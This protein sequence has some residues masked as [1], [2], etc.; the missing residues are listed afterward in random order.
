MAP[1]ASFPK[2][3]EESAPAAHLLLGAG[4]D[5]GFSEV[6]CKESEGDALSFFLG[7]RFSPDRAD[8]LGLGECSFS[9]RS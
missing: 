2:C 4:A 5:H 3:G 7:S 8:V 9:T 6:N 1:L